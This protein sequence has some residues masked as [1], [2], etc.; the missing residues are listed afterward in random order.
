MKNNPIGLAA[1]VAIVAAGIGF[2]GGMKYQ[3][4]KQPFAFRMGGN[5]QGGSIAFR[6]NGNKQAMGVRPV[7]GEIISADDKSVTVKM[8]DG[9]S[10]IVILSDK[11]QINKADQATKD[12][13]NPGT[14]VVVFGTEGS[15]GT[16]TAESIQ[17]N[18][19]QI[20]FGAPETG[21]DPQKQ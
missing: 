7:S 16:V 21:E 2:F 3:Q 10:K 9:S 8:E 1:V 20:R 19:Q 12:E 4:S 17:L 5:G 15:D 18:P 6:R 11:T 13:L 14:K